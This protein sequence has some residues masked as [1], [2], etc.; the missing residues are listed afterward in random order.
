MSARNDVMFGGVGA[1][2]R[3]AHRGP[4]GYSQTPLWV[5]LRCRKEVWLY[6]Y[7]RAAYGGYDEVF[8]SIKTI[9][10]DCEVSR[11]T[12][13]RTLS[14]LIEAGAMSRSPQYRE[15]GGRTANLYL[16][17]WFPPEHPSRAG[18]SAVPPNE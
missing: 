14:L 16:T 12:V 2:D 9:A 8:P 17:E 3:I 4:E 6:D 13:E 5:V 10:K 15:N 1:A 11:R 7:L 18:A